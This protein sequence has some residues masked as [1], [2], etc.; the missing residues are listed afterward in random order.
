[1]LRHQPL[2]QG[3]HF[4]DLS[5]ESISRD[6]IVRSLEDAPKIYVQVYTKIARISRNLVVKYGSEVYLS[7][8]T[9]M[10]HLER[11]SHNQKLRCAKCGVISLAARIDFI[12]CCSIYH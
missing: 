11:M 7:E 6:E 9:T 8:A 10:R 3:F 4:E 2:I 5:P 12:F 1:M